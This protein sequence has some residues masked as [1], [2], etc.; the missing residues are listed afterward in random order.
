MDVAKCSDRLARCGIV[1]ALYGM[2]S[3][4]NLTNSK[5]NILPKEKLKIFKRIY[6]RLIR[7]VDLVSIFPKRLYE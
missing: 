2:N 3:I 1:F 7:P 6:T 4:S 5:Q